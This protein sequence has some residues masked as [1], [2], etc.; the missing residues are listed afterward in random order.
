MTEYLPAPKLR[1]SADQASA[2]ACV[3]LGC[4]NL[5][6]ELDAHAKAVADA[7]SGKNKQPL[8]IHAEAAE[9]LRR[10]RDSL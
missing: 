4:D 5:Y 2:L 6:K 3:I 7:Y 1:L 9:Y 8:A 10:W